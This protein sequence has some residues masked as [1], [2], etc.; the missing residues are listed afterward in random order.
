VK[1]STRRPRRTRAARSPSPKGR[2]SMSTLP[3]DF[4]L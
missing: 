1:A 4:G 3:L 2:P